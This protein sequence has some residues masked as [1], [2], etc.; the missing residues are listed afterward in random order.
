MH[1]HTNLEKRSITAL[2]SLPE[3]KSESDSVI[4]RKV[5][6]RETTTAVCDLGVMWL[7]TGLGLQNKK[8][9]VT[10]FLQIIRMLMAWSP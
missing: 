6:A 4:G 2:P 9:K 3:R 7:W 1:V 10:Y 5:D 8:D